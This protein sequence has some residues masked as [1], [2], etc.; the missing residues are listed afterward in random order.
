MHANDKGQVNGYI[1]NDNRQQEK[2]RHGG[3]QLIHRMG[4]LVTLLV[5]R[6]TYLFY[7]RTP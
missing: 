4:L 1:G 3:H 7:T 5:T 2:Y 6:G